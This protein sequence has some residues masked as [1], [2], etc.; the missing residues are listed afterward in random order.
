MPGPALGCDAEKPL[1]DLFGFQSPL[2]GKGHAAAMLQGIAQGLEGQGFR[3]MKIYLVASAFWTR[4]GAVPIHGLSGLEP[5][6]ERVLDRGLTSLS[7][8]DKNLIS[9][10]HERL[11]AGTNT[12]EDTWHTLLCERGSGR[13]SQEAA[14]AVHAAAKYPDMVIDFSSERVRRRLGL[15]CTNP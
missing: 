8:E 2:K 3:G 7:F 14:M 13:V 1:A 11:R 10:A 15:E 4:L 5:L 6:L 9:V 12:P